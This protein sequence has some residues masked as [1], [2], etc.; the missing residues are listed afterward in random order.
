MIAEKSLAAWIVA[1]SGATVL[2]AA[3]TLT[4]QDAVAWIGIL[5]TAGLAGLNLYQKVREEKRKQDAADL[6][7]TAQ[8]DRAK[9]AQLAGDVSHLTEQLQLMTTEANRWLKMYRSVKGE[10]PGCEA[11]PLTGQ[12]P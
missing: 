10:D 3:Q 1:S 12:T 8:S 11:A 9:V 4:Q 5:T 7:L 6:A 2:A